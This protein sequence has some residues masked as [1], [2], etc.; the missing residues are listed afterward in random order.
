MSNAIRIKVEGIEELNKKFEALSAKLQKGLAKKSLAD[1]INPI[2]NDIVSKAPVGNTAKLA[3]NIKIKMSQPDPYTFMAT[4][5]LDFKAFYGY[6]IEYGWNLTR[7]K[8]F[9][10]HI[11]ARPFFR[12]AWDVNK[13]SSLQLVVNRLK[14]LLK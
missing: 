4:V 13:E 2:H 7:G 8:K 9:I 6:F 10:K 12:P 3:Q 14:E 5:Y 1:G 11:P